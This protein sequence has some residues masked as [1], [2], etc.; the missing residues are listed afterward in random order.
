MLTPARAAISRVDAPWKPLAAKTS[1]AAPRMRALVDPG[2][3]RALS[4]ADFATCRGRLERLTHAGAYRAPGAAVNRC[5]G[6]SVN[7]LL[8]HREAHDL[9]RVV[10]VELLHD[11]LAVRLH[12]V[13]AHREDDR[14]LLVGLALGD[15]L[16]HLA[17]AVAAQ[18]AVVLDL[19]PARVAELG[20]APVARLT[21]DLALVVGLEDATQALAYHGVVVDQEHADLTHLSGPPREPGC[22]LSRAAHALS[23]SLISPQVGRCS[24]EGLEL[25]DPLRLPRKCCV[26]LGEEPGEALGPRLVVPEGGHPPHPGGQPP[27]RR[28]AGR[29]QLADVPLPQGLHLGRHTGEAALEGPGPRAGSGPPGGGPAWRLGARRSGAR[30]HVSRTAAR[31]AGA[32][33]SA[34]ASTATAR[35]GGEPSPRRRR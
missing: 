34:C 16:Q 33:S 10:E 14:D 25:G 27:V 6:P 13:D 5:G 31:P 30:R 17:F 3:S 1:S 4:S 22:R 23:P 28:A 11:V 15:E 2:A 35:D 20:P 26:P 21:H 24:Q 29:R 32:S 18:R 7:D 8:P 19:L 9:R 12:R